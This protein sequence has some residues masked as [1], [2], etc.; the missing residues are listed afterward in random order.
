MLRVLHLK[1][2]DDLQDIVVHEDYRSLKRLV[3]GGIMNTIPYVYKQGD[4]YIQSDY[5]IVYNDNIQNIDSDKN[6]NFLYDYGIGQVVLRGD[7]FIAKL[8]PDS[9]WGSLDEVD[10]GLIKDTFWR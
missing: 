1:R 5:D 3:G 2:G 8:H 9:Y 10:I 7:V 4:S 6:F